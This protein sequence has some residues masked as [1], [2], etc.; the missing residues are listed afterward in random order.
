MA[1]LLKINLE[2]LICLMNQL[3][4]LRKVAHLSKINLETSLFPK[5]G[6]EERNGLIMLP[7]ECTVQE[8]KYF[9]KTRIKKAISKE[10]LQ[11]KIIKN[12]MNNILQLDDELKIIKELEEIIYE[13]DHKKLNLNYQLSVIQE[14]IIEL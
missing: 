4:Y 10:S 1:H 5:D 9:I 2:T 12:R 3:E 7:K 8:V 6:I 14:S 13:I 11:I